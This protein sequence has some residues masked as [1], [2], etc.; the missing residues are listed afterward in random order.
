MCH[1][2]ANKYG[3]GIPNIHPVYSLRHL[4]SPECPTCSNFS[5][6]YVITPTSQQLFNM[7]ICLI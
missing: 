2:N 5:C 4:R 3:T 6:I 7:N 1:T